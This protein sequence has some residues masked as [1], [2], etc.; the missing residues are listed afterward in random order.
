MDPIEE[1]LCNIGAAELLM[2]EKGV[3]RLAKSKSVGLGHLDSMAE[4]YGVNREAMLIRLTKLRLWD[5]L[6][7]IGSGQALVQLAALAGMGV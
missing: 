1:R 4:F 5:A 3:R 7:A 2:P 6:L